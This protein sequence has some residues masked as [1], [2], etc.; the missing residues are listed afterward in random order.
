MDFVDTDFGSTDQRSDF[1]GQWFG[2]KKIKSMVKLFQCYSMVKIDFSNGCT[3]RT[4]DGPNG[5]NLSYNC[6]QS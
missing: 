5:H 6:E 1:C 3:L 4:V 2:C